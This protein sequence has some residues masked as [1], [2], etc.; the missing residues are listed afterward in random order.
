MTKIDS[1]PNMIFKWTDRNHLFVLWFA[2]GLLMTI[3]IL[4]LTDNDSFIW[5]Y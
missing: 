1:A 2:E 5:I 3:S 4:W